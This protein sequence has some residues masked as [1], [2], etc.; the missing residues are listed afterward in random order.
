MTRQTKLAPRLDIVVIARPAAAT[1][2]YSET[3]EALLSLLRRAGAL[4]NQPCSA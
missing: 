2:G 1:A 4:A 3:R